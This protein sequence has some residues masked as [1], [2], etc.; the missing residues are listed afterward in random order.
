MT[1]KINGGYNGLA[2]RE[3]HYNNIISVL[4]RT[5]EYN[6][7]VLSEFSRLNKVLKIDSSGA[8][9]KL[10]QKILDLFPDGIFGPA[11]EEAVK[12]YQRSKTDKLT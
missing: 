6:L 2:D 5:E 10:V 8:E 7:S 9:V 11:T 3:H 1:R 4:R 12:K